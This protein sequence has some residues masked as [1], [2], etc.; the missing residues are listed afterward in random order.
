MGSHPSISSTPRITFEDIITD[1]HNLGLASGDHI[2]V[3]VSYGKMGNIEGGPLTVLNS[4]LEVIGSEGTLMMPTYH[5]L[6]T[7]SHLRRDLVFDPKTS[8]SNKTLF[9]KNL[10]LREGIS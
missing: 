3:S 1:L 5:Y 4:L 10:F 9:Q 7:P 8:I 6:G 2:A